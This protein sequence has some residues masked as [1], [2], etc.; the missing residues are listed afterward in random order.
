MHTKEYMWQGVET[1]STERLS[2]ETGVQINVRS[3]VDAGGQH[4]EYVVLLDTGW[5]FRTLDVGIRDG[6]GL[7]LRRHPS[8]SWFADDEPRPDLAG[9]VDIDLAFSPFTN[10]LPI[11]RLNLPIG[12]S[13]KIVTAYVEVPSLQVTPDPQRYTRLA[14]G[15]YL[16]ES[17]DTDFSRRITVDSDGFVLD[18]PGLFRSCDQ[19]ATEASDRD[20]VL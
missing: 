7:Q 10:T 20:P 11:R 17:L 15:E 14:T 9:V 13:A 5:V 8:G 4:Y 2:I 19:T 6:R 3:T 12:S 18:Y 16:Y 1:P